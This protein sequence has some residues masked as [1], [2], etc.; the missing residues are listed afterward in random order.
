MP[1][2]PYDNHWADLWAGPDDSYVVRL[3]PRDPEFWI[4][5]SGGNT[6]HPNTIKMQ[7]WADR[8]FEAHGSP[9][10]WVYRGNRRD[11]YAKLAYAMN[12]EG[13]EYPSD[14]AISVAEDWEA[15]PDKIPWDEISDEA[16]EE[17]KEELRKT[18]QKYD[19]L[20]AFYR[21]LT[22]KDWLL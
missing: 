16:F 22:G 12:E 6:M 3:N 7:A 21:Y 19:K 17:L 18:R 11:W 9:V 5:N 1:N 2:H 8:M 4:T 10:N 14:E 15:H 13:K 20:N